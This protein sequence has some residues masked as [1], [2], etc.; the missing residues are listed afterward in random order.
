MQRD[1]WMVVAA[2]HLRSFKRDRAIAER[3]SLGAASDDAD[4][5]W[6]GKMLFC[7][8]GSKTRRTL[9]FGLEST[10]LLQE[11]VQRTGFNEKG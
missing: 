11:R 8:D 5:K 10:Q 7:S 9:F 2:E 6:H 1:L 3:G 4:V